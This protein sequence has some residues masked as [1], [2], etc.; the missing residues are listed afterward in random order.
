MIKEEEVED[1]KEE[2]KKRKAPF[3]NDCTHILNLLRLGQIFRN[4]FIS[5]SK[6]FHLFILAKNG[7]IP[8]YVVIIILT[9]IKRIAPA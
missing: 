1:E 4:N 7:I 3:Y 6:L 5:F 9:S 8:V 2:K